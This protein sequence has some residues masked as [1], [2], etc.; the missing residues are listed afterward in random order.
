MPRQ[1]CAELSSHY[2]ELLLRILQRKFVT[3]RHT[4]VKQ[5]ALP[6]SKQWYNEI[7]VKCYIP[8]YNYLLIFR[9]IHGDTVKTAVNHKIS[10]RISL[11]LTYWRNNKTR[12]TG[13][14]KTPDDSL[15]R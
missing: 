4:R 9:K 13:M 12:C 14:M 8:Q 7:N 10:S 2:D 11:S 1:E 6:L 5:Y 15:E 3:D